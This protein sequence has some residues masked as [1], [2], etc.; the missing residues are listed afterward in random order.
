M[1]DGSANLRA[2]ADAAANEAARE[3]RADVYE[4][5]KAKSASK[6]KKATRKKKPVPKSKA[7][8]NPDAWSNFTVQVWLTDLNAT[9]F[10]I[11][12]RQRNRAK[13]RQFTSDMDIFAE[14]TENG[15]RTGLLGYRE[16]VW[17]KNE[18]MD[19]RLIFKMFTDKLNWR[20]TMD[21]MVGR[22]LQLTMGARGLPVTAYSINTNDDD[23]MIYVER[24]ANKWMFM[25]EH[26]SFF[27]MSE[28]GKPEF[29][30]LKRAFINI[31]GD[32][33]LYDQNNEV[34]GYIDGKI[35]SI[36][37]RWHGGVRAEHPQRKKLLTVLKLFG[38]MIVFNGQ[39]RRHM[40]RLYK[41]VLAGK[42]EP[43]LE[44]QEGDLYMNPR[45][46]R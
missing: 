6:K 21:L 15:E 25:P 8:K 42:I 7:K 16:A 22:S 18:G 20:A 29:F 35:M 27:L 31:G 19:R 46:V 43:K 26:F 23:Y 17:K 30:R 11:F 10:G 41:D 12:R 5:G 45:R 4:Q 9:E 24:S 36:A 39:S 33:T 28:S 2:E 40:R 37:G 1:D 44:R 32:Y 3:A 13:S 38:G 14:V 34:V